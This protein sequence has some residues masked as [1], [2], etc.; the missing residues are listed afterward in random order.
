MKKRFSKN[1]VLICFLYC[2]TIITSCVAIPQIMET[3]AAP[4]RWTVGEYTNEWGDKLGNFFVTYD[5]RQTA[6][7]TNTGGTQDIQISEISFSHHNGFYFRTPS[8]VTSFSTREV[9]VI[10]RNKDGT[11]NSFT[12]IWGSPSNPYVAVSATEEL[13]D[14]LKVQGIIIRVSSET[15]RFQFNFPDRF[16]EAYDRLIAREN[17]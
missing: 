11:E 16:P 3:Q 6:S 13:L 8:F 12:G 2:I 17:R 4:L 1:F 7:L 14:A 5:G 10:I 15:T 9:I